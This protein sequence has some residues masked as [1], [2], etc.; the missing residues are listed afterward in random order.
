[1]SRSVSRSFAVSAVFLVALPGCSR[2]PRQWEITVENRSDRPCSFFVTLG[3]GGNSGAKVEDVAKGKALTLI[4]GDTRTVVQTVRVV[5]GKDEQSLT[6]N[7]ELP[8]AK[9]YV[10]VVGAGGKVETSV[11]DR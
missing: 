6:P 10:I 8:V 1:M 4:V 9:R 3:A 2:S 5:C 7:V 11:L